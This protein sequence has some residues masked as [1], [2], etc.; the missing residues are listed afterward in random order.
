MSYGKRRVEL[1]NCSCTFFEKT[2]HCED[3]DGKMRCEICGKTK[4]RN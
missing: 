2:V 4:E 3:S 1:M